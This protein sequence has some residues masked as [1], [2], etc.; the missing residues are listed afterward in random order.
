[1]KS[2]PL[3]VLAVRERHAQCRRPG[4]P[5][6]DAVDHLHGHARSAQVLGLFAAAPKDERVAPLEAHHMLAFVH[7]HEHEL[8][9]EGLRRA[10]AAAALA[11]A[12][13]ARACAAPGR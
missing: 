7:R 2:T 9:D 6:G 4:Q 12:H 11:H 8:F 5:G 13:D 10:L 3:R 1:M